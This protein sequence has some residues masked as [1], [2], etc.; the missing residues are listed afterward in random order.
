M[1][2]DT[3]IGQ[4]LKLFSTKDSEKYSDEEISKLLQKAVSPTVKKYEKGTKQHQSLFTKKESIDR[5]IILRCY[6]FE[7]FES[8]TKGNLHN[9]IYGRRINVIESAL[10]RC[11]IATDENICL[12]KSGFGLSFLSNLRL[13][14]ESLAISRYLWEKG[15][16]EAIRFQDYMEYQISEIE[17]TKKQLEGKYDESFFKP[18]GWISDSKI[19][20][21]SK[22][23]KNLNNDEYNE[24]FKISS[25]YVHSSPYSLQ[26]VWE[27]N[28]RLNG[29]F[30][31]SL[32]DSIRLNEFILTDFLVFIIDCFAEDDEKNSF[33]FFLK[34]IVDNM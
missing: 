5:L 16:S 12:I 23:V 18:Y 2:N 29:Y 13:M 27:M 28:Q 22:L 26:K 6:A 19:N 3:I 1:K 20:S 30:P 21:L 14:L 9:E 8:I 10:L 31:F 33:K 4:F 7:V 32:E 25:N 17:K 11:E 34:V 24:L 15:E